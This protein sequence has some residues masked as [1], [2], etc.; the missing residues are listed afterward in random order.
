MRKGLPQAHERRFVSGRSHRGL[1]VRGNKRDRQ[2]KLI[3][4]KALTAI[5]VYDINHKNSA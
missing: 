3:P 5:G 4:A 2:L 1:S